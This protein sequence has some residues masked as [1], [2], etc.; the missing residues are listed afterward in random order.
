MGALKASLLYEGRAKEDWFEDPKLRNHEL[1]TTKKSVV[2]E[3]MEGMAI[4]ADELDEL[5]VLQRG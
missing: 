3:G 5:P 4:V 1:C 2:G